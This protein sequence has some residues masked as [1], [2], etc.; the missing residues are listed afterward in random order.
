VIFELGRCDMLEVF[1]NKNL[2]KSALVTWSLV[3]ALFLTVLFIWLYW[4]GR[5]LLGEQAMKMLKGNKTPV[6]LFNIGLK[7][8]QGA[9]VQPM[10]VA[11]D[12]RGRIYVAD[13]GHKKVKVFDPN[14]NFLFSFGKE[15]MG[16]GSFVAPVG[17]AVRGDKLYVADSVNMKLQ[18]FSLEGKYLRTLSSVE[19]ARQIGAFR[20]C[21]LDV[22]DEGNL[23]VTDIYYQRVVVLN[24]EG[25]VIRHF[26][27][28]GRGPGQFQY[29]NDVAVDSKGNIY[30]SDSNNNRVQAFDKEGR[31]IQRFPYGRGFG[32]NRGIAVDEKDR[33]YVVDTF[34]NLVKVL[35]PASAG[36]ELLMT[37][38]RQG[39]KNGEF[40][41]PNGITIDKGRIY[42]AD[43]ENNRVVV[44]RR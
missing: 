11:V 30:V 18:E 1:Q 26:G 12:G 13:T 39:N 38:G 2:K 20:P 8:D 7:D 23:Y 25:R 31:L 10:D 29:P 5:F 33:V 6:F 44:F 19:V 35:K 36:G 17:L 40:S 21:G 24:K 9:L 41:F 37:F 14:G 27:Q 43:R 3:L 42:I 15:G 16:D 28:P 22:D 4:Q 32:L 34:G